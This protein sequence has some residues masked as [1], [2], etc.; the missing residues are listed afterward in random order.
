LLEAE[1]R[2]MATLFHWDYPYDLFL[3]GGWLNPDSPK[4]FADFASVV[5]HRLGDRL[6]DWFTLNEPGI[7]LVLG[8]VEGSHA[9]G[10][11]LGAAEFFTAL[12]HTML[13]HGLACKALRDSSPG[14]CRVG[15]APH[16]VTAVP[17]DDTGASVQAAG[18]YTFGKDNNDR[19]FWQQR[20][21]LDP[22]FGVWPTDIESALSDR[23]IEVTPDEL[24]TMAQPLDFLGLNFYSA[25]VVRAGSD[26]TPMVVPDEPGM[27]RTLFD[28]PIR[29]EGL[30]WAVKFH[31]ERYRTPIVISENGLS[32]MDWVALDGKVHDPQRIDFLTRYL[33]QLHRAIAEGI[34]V[35]GYLHWS[36][37]DNF[38][39]AEG[40]KQ[41][42][43]LVHVDYKTQV[44]TIKD[45]G[46]WYKEV[47]DSNGESLVPV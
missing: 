46:R 19:R 17:F 34:D 26:G 8:H 20:L 1:I 10:I 47:C 44:R 16:C 15:Y 41:R 29:P 13:A 12:K 36:L 7:F 31:A 38:E 25:E 39:W 27:P 9:P 22:P 21:Y 40:Y 18:D 42:F 33:G 35:R 6:K 24:E 5:A 2:P 4:W 14:T 23:P 30:Y 37:F 28:W 3:R 11:T 45:S 43:G 32:C